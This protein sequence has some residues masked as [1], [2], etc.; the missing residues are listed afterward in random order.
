[1]AYVCDNASTVG[2]AVWG[3]ACGGLRHCCVTWGPRRVR[4]RGRFGG[5]VP[6]FHNGNRGLFGDIFSFKIKVGVYEK[7][8]KT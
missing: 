1:M 3:G 4:E 7:L 5:F 6:H 8:A 2:A